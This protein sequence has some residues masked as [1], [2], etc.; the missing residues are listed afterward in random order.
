MLIF[1]Q[2]HKSELFN[3]TKKYACKELKISEYSEVANNV[4]K[5]LLNGMKFTLDNLMNTQ[6]EKL[7]ENLKNDLIYLQEQRDEITRH[8]VTFYEI[9]GMINYINNILDFLTK[10]K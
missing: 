9:K 4:S 6:I 8:D 5:Y 10:K 2:L 1:K 7:K 3:L